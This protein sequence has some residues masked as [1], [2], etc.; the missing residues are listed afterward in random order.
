MSTPPRIP[1][2]ISSVGHVLREVATLPQ[3]LSR[4]GYPRLAVF[5]SGSN[6]PSGDL[7]GRL[8]GQELRKCGWS[9]MIVPV[10][11]EESQRR[12]LLRLFQPDLLWFQTCRHS[13]NDA[14]HAFGYPWV[15]DLDDAD[16]QDDEVRDRLERTA[17]G[18]AGVIAGSRYI[19]DWAR[20]FNP[21]V[22][23][24]WTGTP[25]TGGTVPDHH[26]RPHVIAWAQSSP[27]GYRAELDFIVALHARLVARGEKFR[28]RLYGIG[29]PE[30]Q[31]QVRSL[32]PSNAD[33]EL[34][35]FMKY[36]DF[37]TSLRDVAVGLS[38]IIP[39]AAFS[40][41][42]SFGKIL[43][44]LDAGVP[45]ICSDQADHALFFRIESGVVSNDPE[46]WI[47]AISRLIRNPAERN[48]MSAHAGHDF[49]A[50]LTIGKAAVLTDRFL[51][52]LVKARSDHT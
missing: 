45:V 51:R 14:D 38:P 34:F 10:Q 32:F 19:R 11:L 6:F 27:L 39:T 15:L 24:I 47:E 40:K 13:L 22:R 5:P 1:S 44:Y 7:R 12:R 9:T 21:A 50:R 35:P 28:L 29:T 43:G 42:K 52:P 36:R 37:L 20:A 48:A 41:G 25:Q 49:R 16:F 4:R 17:A 8:L 31:A 30:E 18:A 23:V 26:D 2:A 46:V 33:L 3:A